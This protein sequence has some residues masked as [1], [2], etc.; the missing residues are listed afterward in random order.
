M[1]AIDGPVAVADGVWWVGRRLPNDTFQ[2]HAYFLENGGDS[3]LVDPGSPLTIEDTLDKVAQI[4][5]L[6]S[7]RYLVCHHPDPDIAA[8][9][10]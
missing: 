2:C 5:S 3:V 9:L 7:I 4:A 10:P 6:D 8:A 1:G